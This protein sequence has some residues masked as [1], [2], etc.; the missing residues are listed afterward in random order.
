MN[1]I[2][3]DAQTLLQRITQHLGEVFTFE[4]VREFVELER[5]KPL[6]IEEVKMDA[7]TSGAAFHLADCDLVYVARGLDRVLDLDTRLHELIHIASGNATHVEDLTYEQ[8]APHFER[9]M[10]VAVYR[11]KVVQNDIGEHDVETLARIL[12]R[13]VLKAERQTNQFAKFLYS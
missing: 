5:N 7:V 6:V 12:L 8:F 10:E 11:R 13:R 2:S 1:E 4:Q 3:T 9:L